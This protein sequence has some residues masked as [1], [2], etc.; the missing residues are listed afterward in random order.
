M[1]KNIKFQYN[2][3]STTK[4]ISTVEGSKIDIEEKERLLIFEA[5]SV[6]AKSSYIETIITNMIRSL[7]KVVLE[8]LM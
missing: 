7:I 8:F 6:I 2:E 1:A 4:S 5:D 3:K